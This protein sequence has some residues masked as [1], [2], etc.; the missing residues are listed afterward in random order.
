MAKVVA[1]MTKYTAR[2]FLRTST[3]NLFNFFTPKVSLYVSRS[4]V[5]TRCLNA[6]KFKMYI[7]NTK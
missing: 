2:T 4:I 7:K 5:T 3:E 6:G 1:R